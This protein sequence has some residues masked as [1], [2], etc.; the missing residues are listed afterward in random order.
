MGWLTGDFRKTA[1]DCGKHRAG[2]PPVLF[3]RLAATGEALSSDGD[4]ETVP[5]HT[6]MIL[7]IEA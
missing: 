1:V 5:V 7:A 6:S 3:D 2:F 4:G